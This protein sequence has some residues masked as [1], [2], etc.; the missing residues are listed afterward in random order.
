MPKD[1]ECVFWHAHPYKIEKGHIDASKQATVFIADE[2][3]HKKTRLLS[4]LTSLN[5]KN[6]MIAIGGEPVKTLFQVY[7][8]Q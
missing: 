6:K 3:H 1:C 2:S 8:G 5:F 4:E 7:I